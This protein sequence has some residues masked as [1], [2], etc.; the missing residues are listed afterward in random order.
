MTDLQTNLPKL[1]ESRLDNEIVRRGLCPSRTR[2]QALIKSKAIKVNGK[3]ACKASTIV[4]EN[5][6]IFIDTEANSAGNYVSRGAIKLVGALEQFTAQGLPSV[7]GKRCLD[8]GASTGG[9]TQ[10]LLKNG[11]AHVIALDVGHDQLDPII[12]NDVNVTDM[13]GVNI[14]AVE[15]DDLPYR[16][17]FI[18]SDVSFISLTYV[19]PVIARVCAPS[20]QIILLVKPQFEVGKGNLGK[21]GIVLVMSAHTMTV[22][23]SLFKILS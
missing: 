10:V 11:A 20:A 4:T 12:A 14:R 23:N 13:S 16:P 2:A 9:F 22:D 19:I 17:E 15:K 21:G 8:I 7:E 5:D 18:V 6:E 3:V 1:L